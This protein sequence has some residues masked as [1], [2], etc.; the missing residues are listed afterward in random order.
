MEIPRLPISK[1]GG[2]DPKLSQDAPIR[3]DIVA[4]S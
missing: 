1:Y 2:H 4:W 3:I